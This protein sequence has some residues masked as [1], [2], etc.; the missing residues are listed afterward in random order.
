LGSGL[1][2]YHLAEA[3]GVSVGMD[4]DVG[5]G[6]S[7]SILRTMSEAY[8]VAQLQGKK[9]TALQSFYLAT[10]GGAKALNLDREIGNFQ[11]GKEADF[12]VIDPK[13]TELMKIRL[14][15]SQAHHQ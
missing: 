13:A 14:E 4:T 15:N 12:I 3:K 2:P 11:I 9:M 10:L 6:T 5:A 1:F 8:K 7:F